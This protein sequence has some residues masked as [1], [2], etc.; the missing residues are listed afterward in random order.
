MNETCYKIK[1]EDGKHY[2]Y[3]NNIKLPNQ[4]CSTVYQ[5]VELS[6]KKLAKVTITVNAILEK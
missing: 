5:D 3:Y 2:L 6:T 1:V 4:V